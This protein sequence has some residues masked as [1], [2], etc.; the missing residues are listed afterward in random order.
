LCFVGI[1]SGDCLQLAFQKR[2]K[3]A[4][5]KRQRRRNFARRCEI[6]FLPLVHLSSDHL[7]RT[8]QLVCRT[9]LGSLLPCPSLRPSGD[10]SGPTSCDP[11]R[12]NSKRCE[13]THEIF[14]SACHVLKICDH[15]VILSGG[16][17]AWSLRKHHGGNVHQ[18]HRM[19]RRNGFAERNIKIFYAD[20]RLPN[21]QQSLAG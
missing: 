7:N 5:M 11:L 18:V 9:D 16:W 20:G 17:N 8:Q 10:A 21:D 4:L 19:L 6:N 12:E 13:T 1:G 15:A 14:E 3:N 2:C